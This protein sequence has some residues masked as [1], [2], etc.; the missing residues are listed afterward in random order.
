[1]PTCPICAVDV[2][3][4]SPEGI[5]EGYAVTPCGHVF[6]SVCIKRYLAITD[7]PMCPVCRADLFHACQHPVLPSLYDPKKSRLSRDEAA[8]KAFPDEPRYSDCSF[9]RHRKIKY[10]RRMRR[11]EV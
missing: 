3:T 2:G 10:A 11:Q 5:K 1:D 8:A 7:K 6:G 9:C 4:R